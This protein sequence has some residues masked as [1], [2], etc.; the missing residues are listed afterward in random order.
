MSGEQLV[1]SKGKPAAYEEL[2]PKIRQL[3]EKGKELI[4]NSVKSNLIGQWKLGAI[5]I[6]ME[7]ELPTDSVDST[8]PTV[9]AYWFNN[10]ASLTT[11]YNLRNVAKRFSA[12]DVR[13]MSEVPLRNNSPLTW[14]H[15]LELQKV[16]DPARVE[17]LL[18]QIRNNSWSAKE[19]ALQ[20]SGS[21]DVAVG[22]SGGR[23]PKIPSSPI[24]IVKK[25]TRS[26]QQT[27]NY[28]TQVMD[29]IEKLL[30]AGVDYDDDFVDSV[31]S[32]IDQ[33]TDTVQST[34]SMLQKLK[35]LKS[36][37]GKVVNTNGKAI[38]TGGAKSSRA[39]SSKPTKAARTKG[40]KGTKGKKSGRAKT[41]A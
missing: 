6:G 28:L 26:V 16:S 19:L 9:A 37:A 13:K 25:I 36:I 2:P 23:K 20:L 12:D 35:Q 40:T 34:A 30:A 21:R 17:A 11:L 41:G 39:K 27:G 29:P 38:N 18:T 24:S 5:I 1:V 14:S 15:L 22:R 10:E 4:C 31:S 3:A 32:A 8:L 33:L 7:A